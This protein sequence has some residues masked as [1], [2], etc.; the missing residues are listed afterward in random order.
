MSPR[1]LATLQAAGRAGFG[2]ALVAT[3]G[4]T[5]APWIGS[6]ARRPGARVL[7]IAMGAR[8]AALGGGTLAAL[9]RGDDLRPW[10]AAGLAADLSDLVATVASRRHLPSTGVAAV[11]SLAASSVA[12]GAWLYASVD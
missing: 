7:A 10:L 2:A 5:A 6:D 8:D 3:P 12:L 1:T 9:R 4:L 11:A